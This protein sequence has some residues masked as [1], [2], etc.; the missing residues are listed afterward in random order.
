VHNKKLVWSALEDLWYGISLREALDHHKADLLLYFKTKRKKS[1]Y[2][3]AFDKNLTK[4]EYLLLV[5]HGL[6]LRINGELELIDYEM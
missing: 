2:I 6:D 3:P 4:R 1:L 5:E